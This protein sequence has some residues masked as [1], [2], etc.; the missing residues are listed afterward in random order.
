MNDP[1]YID[2]FNQMN[3]GFFEKEYIRR[4]PAD[5]I[6]EEMVLPLKDFSPDAVEIPVPEGIAFGFYKGDVKALLESVA[7]VDEGW[8]EYFGHND[9][10]YCA[11]DGDRVVSFCIA[12]NMGAHTLAGKPV[13]VAGPGCVGTIPSYRR[14]GIGLKMVQNVT[15][16]LKNEGYDLSWIHYTG[17]GPWYAKLGYETVLRWN[18]GGFVG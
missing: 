4:I 8:V 1:E 14:R 11:L 9:R 2:L 7:A 17:V 15:A 6:C 12:D 10:V 18:G 3:P 5:H 16:I 13:K